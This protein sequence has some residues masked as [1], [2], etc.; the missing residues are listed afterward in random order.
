MAHGY[1]SNGF[2][3]VSVG[4]VVQVVQTDYSTYADLGTGNITWHWF[5]IQISQTIGDETV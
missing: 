5:S 2:P 3:S 4:Q 1:T